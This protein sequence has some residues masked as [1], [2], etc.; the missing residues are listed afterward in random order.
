MIEH[1]INEYLEQEW[2]GGD[3]SLIELKSVT[4]LLQRAKSEIELLRKAETAIS[5]LES[6][7]YYDSWLKLA[8]S[9]M[10]SPETDFKIFFNNFMEAND[11]EKPTQILY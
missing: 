1:D 2:T 9:W 10:S 4:F 8:D 11:P 3:D 5:Q 6:L 7:K